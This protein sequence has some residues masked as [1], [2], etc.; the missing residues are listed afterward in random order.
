MKKDKIIYWVSTVLVMLLGGLPAVFYFNTPAVVEGFK[1]L[2][3]P[4]YFR[5]ELAIGKLLGVALLLV[6][7]VPARIKEWAYVGFGITF[8]SAALA[9]GVVEGPGKAILPLVDLALLLLSYRYFRKRN[10][11]AKNGN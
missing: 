6:P 4:P 1:Q 8:I 2:G 11:P 10:D 7:A 5:I 3:F 9:H